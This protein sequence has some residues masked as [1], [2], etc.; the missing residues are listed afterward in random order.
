MASTVQSASTPATS[1]PEYAEPTIQFSTIKEL[2]SRVAQVIRDSGDV[3]IVTGIDC[4]F[5]PM[6]L[7]TNCLFRCLC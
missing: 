3:L 2:E 4:S 5:L 7:H 1:I 6:K